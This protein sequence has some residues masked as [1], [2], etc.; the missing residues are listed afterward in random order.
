MLLTRFLSI[1][2]KMKMMKKTGL[3]LEENKFS[4]ILEESA[5]EDQNKDKESDNSKEMKKEDEQ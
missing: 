1:Q 4:K 3:A 2:L 5:A